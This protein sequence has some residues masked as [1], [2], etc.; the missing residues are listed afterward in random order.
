MQQD[1]LDIIVISQETFQNETLPKTSRKRKL[2][3][4]T[5]NKE[6]VLPKQKKVFIF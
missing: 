2:V 1:D 6:N 4:D 3:K 5:H